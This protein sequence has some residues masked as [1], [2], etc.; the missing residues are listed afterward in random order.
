MNQSQVQDLSQEEAK[1]EALEETETEIMR[2]H[3]VNLN[4]GGVIRGLL[5]LN[6]ILGLILGSQLIRGSILW[7][8]SQEEA[9]HESED[10]AKDE[11]EDE[12]M[13][14]MTT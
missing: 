4:I 11:A 7:I 2:P 6:F 3:S 5:L 10:E 13:R 1:E 12:T 8:P 9:E 14:R